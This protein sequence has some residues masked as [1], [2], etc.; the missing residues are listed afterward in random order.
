MRIVALAAFLMGGALAM[1]SAQGGNTLEVVFGGGYAFVLAKGDTLDIATIKKPSSG[2]TD[3]MHHPL[4]MA[5]TKGTIDLSKTTVPPVSLGDGS[6]GW[7]FTGRTVTVLDNG[8]EFP[9]E[10]VTLPEYKAVDCGQVKPE[11]VNNRYFLADITRIAK[12]T[13]LQDQPKTL[14]DGL[15]TL[16]GGTL[17]VKKLSRG[18]YTFVKD[19]VPVRKQ[20]LA[21]GIAGVQYSHAFSGERLVL[22]MSGNGKEDE[23]HIV[24]NGEQKI[25]LEIESRHSMTPKPGSIKF[26]KHFYRLLH[27]K[28]S[29]MEIPDW[30]GNTEGPVT[31]GEACPPGF[32]I[33]P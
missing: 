10:K 5:V 11:D 4:K 13:M 31:P 14:F 22:K 32:Y 24:P 25:R 3:Y 27:D 29:H 28:V 17:E 8:Q 6:L 19:G 30:D 1:T 26:F 9:N 12:Q 23:I 20:R 33:I 21:D 2:A 16:H 7:N 18:C 15:I